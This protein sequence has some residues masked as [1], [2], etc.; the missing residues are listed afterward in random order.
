MKE[1]YQLN[2]L[3]S[4]VGPIDYVD[5]ARHSSARVYNQNTVRK[6][7]DYQPL[8]RYPKIILQTVSNVAK[9]PVPAIDTDSNRNTV[10]LKIE[11]HRGT[12]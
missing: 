4:N 10:R 9:M 11:T 8:Y 7:G 12:R 3:F 6:N 2:I 5:I 1:L